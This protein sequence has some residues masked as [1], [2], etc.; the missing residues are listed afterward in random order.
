MRGH[1]KAPFIEPRADVGHFVKMLVDVEPGKNLLGVAS[2]VSW[3]EWM[4]LFGK[5][6]GA[7]NVKYAEM[8]VAEMAEMIPGGFGKE[9]ADMYQYIDRF[10]YDGSDPSVVTPEQVS[11][12]VDDVS[13]RLCRAD[14][15]NSL[16]S[17]CRRS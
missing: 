5:R 11:N 16:A 17:K 2:W 3:N 4:D 9:L 15:I 8:S 14:K 13:C 6:V 7:K 12:S 1:V 10:G